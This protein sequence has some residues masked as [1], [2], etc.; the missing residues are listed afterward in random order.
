MVATIKTKVIGN[1]IYE[2]RPGWSYG[3]IGGHLTYRWWPVKKVT[4]TTTNSGVVNS[5]QND[6][7]VYIPAQDVTFDGALFKPNTRLY[8][9]FDGKDVTSYIQPTMSEGQATGDPLITDAGGRMHGIFHL[10][11]N[12]KTIRFVQGKKE[13][14]FIDNDKNDGTETTSGIVYFTYEGTPNQ[15]E[16]QDVGGLQASYNDVDPTVQSFLV[17]ESGGVYL[18][19]MN[20]YFLTKDNKYPI[21]LQ[22]REVIDD[23]VSSKYLANSNVVLDPANI[24]VSEDGSLATPVTFTSPIY[25]QEGKEYAIYLV[26]NAPATYTLATCVYGETDSKNQVS[27]KDPRV[28]T[29]LK[30][31]G[32]GVWLRDS[33][34]GIKFGLFKCAFDTTS[35]YTLSLDNEDLGT[36]SLPNNSLAT[37]IS[38][39]R[40]TVTDKNHS[41]NADDYVTIAGL[42]ADTTYG[43]ISSQ[44]INGV[45]RIDS[46]TWDTY[47]FTTVLINGVET[48]IPTAA[49]ASVVFGTNVLTDY[50]CQYDNILINNTQIALTKTSLDYTFKG[51]SGKSLDGNETPNIMDSNF[52]E[53]S[54]KVDYSVNRVKKVNSPYNEANLNPGGNKSLQ[55]D[56]KFKTDNENVSPVIDLTNTNVVL[57]ENL[58]NNQYDDELETDNGKGIARYITRDVALANQSDGLQVKFY[59]NIQSN[60]N[61]RVYYKTLPV[62]STGSLADQPWVE[63]TPDEQIKKVND[64]L[65]FPE[66][67]FTVY[68]LPLFK[69]FKTKVLMTSS[70]STK[71]PLIK[72]YRAIA[73]QSIGAQG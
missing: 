57:V 52:T 32:A 6:T 30:Y 44:Y 45:H 26:T 73:F 17:L 66:I 63:M 49:T 3:G 61:V 24:N 31:L 11:N 60:A 5:V 37:T 53:I 21:L 14:K 71:P 67:K 25:L 2:W 1:Y 34:K 50:S 22:I 16:S 40:I 4:T 27:T 29:L 54:N 46:V 42:P 41:F 20:L 64:S 43:G 62:G 8:A 33:T 35:V 36:H 9:F 15:T 47:S 68:D 23:A 51:L 70:D 55:V 59:G 28:G 58:I 69:A 38:T 10:P 19:S 12:A 39:N 56:I 13:L 65:T 7:N 72:R 18:Q 48:D